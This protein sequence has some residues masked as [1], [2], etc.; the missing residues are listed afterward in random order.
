MSRQRL[1]VRLLLQLDSRVG[2]HSGEMVRV[3]LICDYAAPASLRTHQGFTS[4]LASEFSHTNVLRQ[5]TLKSTVISTLV[6]GGACSAICALGFLGSGIA[7]AAPDVVGMTHSEAVSAI[8]EWGGTAKV[9][10]TVG[11]RQDAMIECLVSGATE[12]PFVRVGGGGDFSHAESEVLLTLNCNRG[13][14]N[15]S[16][17][18]ASAASPA[19]KAFQEKVDALNEAEAQQTSEDELSGASEAEPAE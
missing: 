11:S 14:A 19:G 7:S 17:P 18:G 8:E 12:A 16:V 10:V 2:G 1:I 15:A 6:A 9:A 4:M 3:T 5:G 13:V